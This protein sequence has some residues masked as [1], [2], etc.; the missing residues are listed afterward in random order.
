VVRV[1]GERAAVDRP[2]APEGPALRA[3]RRISFVM[4]AVAARFREGMRARAGEAKRGYSVPP[5]APISASGIGPAAELDVHVTRRLASAGAEIEIEAVAR[6]ELKTI[7]RH[8]RTQVEAVD[9][10]D[11]GGQVPEGQHVD[12]AGWRR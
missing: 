11:L 4:G 3:S 5:T 1:A 7:G 2:F 10:D 12:A 8:R 9:R 6:C